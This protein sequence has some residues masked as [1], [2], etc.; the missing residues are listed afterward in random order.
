MKYSIPYTRGVIYL[1]EN[2]G[3]TK[4]N[5]AI[6]LLQES[7]SELSGQSNSPLQSF[8]NGIQVPSPH[9]CPEIFQK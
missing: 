9:R 8:Q 4:Q 1:E 6:N 2:V 7:S 3:K 5:M